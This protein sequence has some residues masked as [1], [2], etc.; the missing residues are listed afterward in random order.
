MINLIKIDKKVEIL[1]LH[2]YFSDLLEND[3]IIVKEL[4]KQIISNL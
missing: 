2:I 3:K 4:T 1:V